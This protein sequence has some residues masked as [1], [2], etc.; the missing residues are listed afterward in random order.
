MLKILIAPDSFKDSAS[1][2]QVASS[3]AKG[4]RRASDSFEV[5]EVPVADGGEGTVQA[6][7]NAT[8]GNIKKAEVHDPLLRKVIAEW[9][10]SGTSGAAV[11]EMAAASGI[12]LLKPKERNPWHTTTFGTGE[13]IKNA[14]DEGCRRF[15]IGIG[16]SATNDGGVG[17]AMALGVKFLNAKGE[18]IGYGGGA[19]SD[20]SSIDYSEIDQ[21]AKDSEFIVACDVNNPLC[22]PQG[23][24]FVYGG[25]K[26]ADLKMQEGLDKNLYHLSNT[27]KAFSGKEIR[28]IP[29]AGAAGGLGAGFLAFL[30]S[31]LESGFGIVSNEV[32][33]EQHCQ[34]ADVVITGE[35]KIDDQT[36]FGKTP[37]GVADIAK[38]YNKKVVAIAGTLGRGYTELYSRGF[39]AIFSVIDKPLSLNE[40]L[41]NSE[42]LIEN[43]GLTIGRLLKK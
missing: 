28:D 39:D 32:D 2:T 7:I 42:V 36:K 5:R 31:K 12:E 24:S 20:L 30:N 21:R 22:G 23:A 8:H 33:L 26:G 43:A 1:A 10:V 13:L 41:Q 37:Q 16:G 25:Q 4:L 14:L 40:A 3:L 18:S 27:I 17:M 29:G 9:G 11:M 35:G 19:L 15:I 34:W 38:K 6:I